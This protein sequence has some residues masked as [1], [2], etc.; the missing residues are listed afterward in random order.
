MKFKMHNLD[1]NLSLNNFD[2]DLIEEEP[3]FKEP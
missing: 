1:L 2:K 3:L